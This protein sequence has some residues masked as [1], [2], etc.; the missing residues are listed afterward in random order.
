MP[1]G[2]IMIFGWHWTGCRNR[3]TCGRDRPAISERANDQSVL[4]RRSKERIAKDND[5]QWQSNR[6]E[7]RRP[8]RRERVRFSKRAAPEPVAPKIELG[9]ARLPT[10]KAAFV[11][12]M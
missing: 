10:R 3:G 1:H 12:P 8:A 5:A 2:C 9:A 4:T 11:E 7:E 6:T